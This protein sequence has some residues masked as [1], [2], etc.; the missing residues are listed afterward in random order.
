MRAALK[1]LSYPDI[2]IR[3]TYPIERALRTAAGRPVLFYKPWDHV[4]HYGDHDIPV[5]IFSPETEGEHAIL[6]FFHGGGWVTGNIDSYDKV[7]RNMAKLTRPRSVVSVDYRLAP[8]YRFPAAPEDCYAVA[9]EIFLDLS[10]FGMRAD[11]ITLIG[12]SAGANLAAAVSLMARDRGGI[13]AAQPNP[14]LSRHGRP[15]I[16]KIPPFRRCVKMEPTIC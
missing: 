13:P 3:K 10:L 4:V 1:A 5:R 11:Q 6:L 2:D 7:C 15:T 8:E 14:Y 9:R 16:R 12:D